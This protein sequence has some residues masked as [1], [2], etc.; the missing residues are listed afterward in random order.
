MSAVEQHTR[1]NE[2]S[3]NDHVAFSQKPVLGANTNLR[4]EFRSCE[5]LVC[6]VPDPHPDKNGVNEDFRLYQ[7]R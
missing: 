1:I 5:M 7:W 3:K 2:Q 4:K 6:P